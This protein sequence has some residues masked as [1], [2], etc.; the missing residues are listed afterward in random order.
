[1]ESSQDLINNVAPEGLHWYCLRAKTRREHIA[2]EHLRRL[3]NLEVVCPR[4]RIKRAVRGQG[5][6]VFVEPVFPAYFFSRFDYHQHW[7]QINAMPAVS[8]IVRVGHRVPTLPDVF[9]REMID[10]FP[11]EGTFVQDHVLSEGEVVEILTGS[12]MGQEGKVIAIDESSQRV[13]ILLEFL[14]RE[15]AVQFPM[16]SLQRKE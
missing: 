14:G 5:K 12:L 16:D 10:S 9:I 13:A 2:G 15:V 11:S 6:K 7:R 1:M 3:M 4:M 8:G